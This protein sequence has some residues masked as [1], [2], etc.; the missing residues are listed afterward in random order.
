MQYTY[1]KEDVS[2]FCQS[3][4][5]TAEETVAHESKAGKTRSKKYPNTTTPN[6]YIYVCMCDLDASGRFW[7]IRRESGACSY[8][9]TAELQQVSRWFNIREPFC[10]ETG[11]DVEPWKI[12]TFDEWLYCDVPKKYRIFPYPHVVNFCAQKTKTKCSAIVRLR[13]MYIILGR[14]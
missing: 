4:R 7:L 11:N 6:I 14:S 1:V 2:F 13:I 5:T 12:H 9:G 3:P 10:P 8:S